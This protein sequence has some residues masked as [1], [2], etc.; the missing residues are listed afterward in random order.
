MMYYYTTDLTLQPEK[1]DLDLASAGRIVTVGSCLYA[2]TL[3]YWYVLV[4]NNNYHL[5]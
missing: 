1:P 4:I 2:P 3:Y 5:I